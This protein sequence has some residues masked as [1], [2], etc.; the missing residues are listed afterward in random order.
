MAACLLIRVRGVVNLSL[1]V[2]VLCERLHRASEREAISSFIKFFIESRFVL[3]YYFIGDC[4]VW[5]WSVIDAL[6]SLSA[7]L[8]VNSSPVSHTRSSVQAQ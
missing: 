8:T 2:S 5:L 1:R 6:D 4:F 7:L 3:N